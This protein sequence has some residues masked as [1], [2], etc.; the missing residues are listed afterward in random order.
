MFQKEPF[1][2]MIKKSL[3]NRMLK[4]STWSV[5]MTSQSFFFFFCHGFHSYFQHQL[6][7]MLTNCMTLFETIK[8]WGAGWRGQPL[9]GQWLG[10]SWQVMSNC[11]ITTVVFLHFSSSILENYFYVSL[12]VLLLFSFFLSFFFIPQ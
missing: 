6:Q 3:F 4:S 8:L 9:L 11:V 5:F 2:F 1:F 10:I 12:W 7:F